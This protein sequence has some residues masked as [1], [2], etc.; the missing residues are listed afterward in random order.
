LIL[1]YKLQ[2]SI[3]G[4]YIPQVSTRNLHLEIG[5][6]SHIDIDLDSTTCPPTTTS[7]F[8]IYHLLDTK[9]LNNA[10]GTA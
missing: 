3:R 8:N 9:A 5:N 4:R 10:P 1:S 2:W 7:T 6:S